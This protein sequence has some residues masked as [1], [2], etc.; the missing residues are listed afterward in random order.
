M[1]ER[2]DINYQEPKRKLRAGEKVISVLVAAILAYI[3][4][5]VW[6]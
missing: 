5:G 6:L 1:Y 2:F 3:F 4:C